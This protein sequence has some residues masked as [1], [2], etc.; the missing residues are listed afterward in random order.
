MSMMLIS[1]LISNC[2]FTPFAIYLLIDMS[3][4]ALK[5]PPKLAP[6]PVIVVAPVSCNWAVSK[7]YPRIMIVFHLRSEER[8]SDVTDPVLCPTWSPWFVPLKEAD[9]ISRQPRVILR[10][11]EGVTCL[12][13]K[14]GVL[15]FVVRWFRSPPMAR[16]RAVHKP[17][18]AEH[19]WIC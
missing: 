15:G 17:T 6:S 7:F 4:V 11:H 13:A 12:L 2:D 9:A 1:W 5:V 16:C 18:S 3:R 8:R 19:T 14:S 10:V